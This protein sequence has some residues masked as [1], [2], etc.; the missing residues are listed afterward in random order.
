M[1]VRSHCVDLTKSWFRFIIDILTSQFLFKHKADT[2]THI[3]I[4]T[5]T[6]IHTFTDTKV[7][8]IRFTVLIQ[9]QHR[10]PKYFTTVNFQHLHL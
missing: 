9:V 2:Y 1:L 5:I 4:H 6:Y 7:I 3:Y 8:Y 10:H